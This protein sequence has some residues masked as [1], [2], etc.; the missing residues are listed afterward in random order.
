MRYPTGTPYQGPLTCY[1]DQIPQDDIIR[2]LV[3]GKP[4]PLLGF[5]EP[6]RYGFYGRLLEQLSNAHAAFVKEGRR[7]KLYQLRRQI[8]GEIGDA[9]Y[10]AEIIPDDRD[11]LR[12]AL[13][14]YNRVGRREGGHPVGP[15]WFEP[16]RSAAEWVDTREAARILGVSVSYMGVLAKQANAID[17]RRYGGQ[18]RMLIRRDALP[19][20]ANRPGRHTRKR[21]YTK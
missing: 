3:Y 9:A 20:L 10:A 11:P 1:D 8:L 4:K 12:G 6:I 17:T 21:R 18:R 7:Y 2:R 16:E 5:G 13:I 19:A 15:Q 14:I